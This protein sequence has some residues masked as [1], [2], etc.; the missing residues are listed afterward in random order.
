MTYLAADLF[1]FAFVVIARLLRTVRKAMSSFS[2]SRVGVGGGGPESDR[3]LTWADL[4]TETSTTFESAQ[5][6]VREIIFWLGWDCVSVNLY[7]NWASLEIWP[8]GSAFPLHET[9]LTTSEKK[10]GRHLTCFSLAR[11]KISTL[12]L[13]GS[14][15]D[16]RDGLTLL[17]V[18]LPLSVT[19][20]FGRHLQQP[21]DVHQQR[22]E[23]RDG[24]HI[25][26]ELW[27]V[28]GSARH[29]H[30]A[31]F[32]A[33]VAARRR[34]RPGLYDAV[35]VCGRKTQNRFSDTNIWLFWL[36]AEPYEQTA[37][38]FAGRFGQPLLSFYSCGPF[39]QNYVSRCIASENSAAWR[40]KLE[41]PMK[42]W[43]TKNTT[44]STTQIEFDTESRE[45]WAAS[46][47]RSQTTV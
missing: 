19:R 46:V 13:R 16:K 36:L 25:R 31:Q 21:L 14:Q 40:A 22:F 47:C 39:C 34:T 15:R 44:R 9:D 38:T 35:I 17:V 12:D 5:F 27:E 43:E 8:K 24:R 32:V 29:R 42:T 37:C 20:V 41:S 7:R 26:V 6:G 3:G 45:E 2:G 18:D 11:D 10:P 4:K 28:Q 30:R 1:H 23:R 33:C